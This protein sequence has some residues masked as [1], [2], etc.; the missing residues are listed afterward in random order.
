MIA[1][2]IHA[3]RPALPSASGGANTITNTAAI[4]TTD[5]RIQVRRRPKRLC[6]RSL[7]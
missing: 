5:A 2:A 7:R 4:G 1:V 3:M 6:V